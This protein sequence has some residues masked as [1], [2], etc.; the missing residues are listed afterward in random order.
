MTWVPIVI[1][2]FLWFRTGMKNTLLGQLSFLNQSGRLQGIRTL[3]S[4]SL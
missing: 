2:G 3:G 4:I 1:V